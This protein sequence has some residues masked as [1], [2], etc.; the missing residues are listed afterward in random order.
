MSYKIVKNDGAIKILITESL[1]AGDLKKIKNE[2]S[3]VKEINIVKLD[4]RNCSYLQS[5]IVTEII[6]FKKDLNNKNAKLILT[7]VHEAV[8]QL[9]EISNLINF[10]DIE[11]DFSSYSVNELVDFFLDPDN[12]DASSDYIA[13]N[14]NDTFKQK[15]IELLYNTDPILKEYAILTIGKAFDRSIINKIRESLDDDV[16]N[17]K[18]AAIIVLGWLGDTDSKDKIYAFLESDYI[19]V[20][21]SAAATIALLSDSK[22]SERMK[23]L[24]ANP[25]DRLK[26]I[27]IN[28]LKLINDENSYIC[29]KDMLKNG[30]SDFIKILLTR[31]ISFYDY[32][33]TAD[34]LLDLLKDESLK[35]SEEAAQSLIR[36]KAKSKIDE[37]LTM[38]S[39]ENGWFAYYATKTIGGICDS[40]TCTNFLVKTYNTASE[41]VKIAIIQAVGNIGV[42]CT[43]FLL[44][45]MENGGEHIRREAL[46]SLLKVNK[47]KAVP[48]ARDMLA[49]DKSSIVR[50]KATEIL[51]NEKPS[52]YRKFLK[53]I[54][55]RETSEKIKERI[56]DIIE[57]I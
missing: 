56:L 38:I 33:E 16:S 42:D 51:G 35:V 54:Y 21:E 43:E 3:D 46:N 25:D 36:I 13:E 41:N 49:N 53:K 7:N 18:K 10:I 14:Y 29:L 11:K 45:L 55:N 8:I 5:N 50:L 2:L 19:D 28:A 4:L 47:N 30:T 39:N 9:M 15:M 48:A 12:C 17:V 52:G 1:K 26:K 31:A 20:V 6:D 23:Q 57:E 22:D 32:P 24:L 34:I 40:E 27:I 44:D 37:I